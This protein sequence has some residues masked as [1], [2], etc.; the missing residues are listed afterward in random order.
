MQRVSWQAGGA[1][2][3]GSEGEERASETARSRQRHVQGQSVAVGATFAAYRQHIAARVYAYA[4][5]MRV[6]ALQKI[7]CAL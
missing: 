1:E 4:P 2:G 5:L 7:L 6:H 3:E